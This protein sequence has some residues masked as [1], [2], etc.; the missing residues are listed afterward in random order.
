MGPGAVQPDRSGRDLAW[1][2]RGRGHEKGRLRR[3]GR[4][5]EVDLGTWEGGDLNNRAGERSLVGVTKHL[6]ADCDY[7]TASENEVNAGDIWLRSGLGAGG[8]AG[9]GRGRELDSGWWR[10][11]S[12][13]NEACGRGRGAARGGG[14][15]RGEVVPG[16][17]E[18]GARYE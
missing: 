12:L 3:Q 15:C 1:R 5:S 13:G 8:G 16:E 14:D 11:L 7:R 4:A 10:E 17:A 2:G 18:N 9:G 6:G